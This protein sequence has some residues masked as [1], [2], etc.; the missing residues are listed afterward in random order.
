MYRLDFVVDGKVLL[1]LKAVSKLQEIFSQQVLSYL[2]A[3]DLR[4]H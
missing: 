3:T 2:K 1:E 4:S